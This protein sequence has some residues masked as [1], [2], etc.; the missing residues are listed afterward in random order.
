M[1]LHSDWTGVKYDGVYIDVK[2]DACDAVWSRT[3]RQI[4]ASRKRFGNDVDVCQ[5]CRAKQSITKK[6]QCSTAY[7]DSDRSVE[8]GRIMR[9]SENYQN[10][11]HKIGRRGADNHMYGKTH[12]VDTRKKMSISRTGKTGP[13]ATAWKGGKTSL[14]KRAKKLIGGRDNWFG[15]VIARDKICQHCGADK[16]LD[17]HHINPLK[18]IFSR[19]MASLPDDTPNEVRLEI[20]RIDT[21]FMDPLLVNGITLCRQCHQ[22]IHYNW[23]SHTTRVTH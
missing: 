1:I 23:G 7:W 3:R 2:C 6:P 8:H 11:R 14:Y 22:N 12:S 19:I 10:A 9:E 5:S 15:R 18:P 21:D 16:K 17:A 20:L 4:M 13:N